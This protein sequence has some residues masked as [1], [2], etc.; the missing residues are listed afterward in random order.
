M[1]LCLL[2]AFACLYPFADEIFQFVAGPMMAALP[3]DSHLISKQVASPF[4]TP[5]RATFWAALFVAMPLLLYH[6]WRLI[7]AWL[8]SSKRR[9]A[10]PFI[11]ASAALFYIGMSFAFFVVL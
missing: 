7:D 2:A 10:L 4:M 11:V 8:P 6:I 9:I 3:G 1:I 5:L